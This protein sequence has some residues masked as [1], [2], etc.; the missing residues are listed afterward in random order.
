MKGEKES[1][2]DDGVFND[3]FAKVGLTFDDVLLVPARSSIA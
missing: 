3:R 1:I 2:L